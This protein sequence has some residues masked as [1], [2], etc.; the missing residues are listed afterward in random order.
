MTSL[1]GCVLVAIFGIQR[2][3]STWEFGFGFVMAVFGSFVGATGGFLFVRLIWRRLRS[4]LFAS[5]RWAFPIA[6]ALAYTA[7]LGLG[8]VEQS[9]DYIGPLVPNR[10]GNWLFAVSATFWS[11]VGSLA[12]TGLDRGAARRSSARVKKEG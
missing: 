9:T 1:V 11:T 4:A 8:A 2:V 5:R 6:C 12:M 10:G 3:W 7:L